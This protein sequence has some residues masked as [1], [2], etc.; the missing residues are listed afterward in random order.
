[1]RPGNLRRWAAAGAVLILMG[2]P[3]LVVGCGGSND[4]PTFTDTSETW[5]SSTTSPTTDA[6]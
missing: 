4:S 2:T 5:Q 1:M 3:P 6:P